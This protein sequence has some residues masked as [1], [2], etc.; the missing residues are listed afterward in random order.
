MMKKRLVL[1]LVVLLV[2]ISCKKKD[3][4]PIVNGTVL[5]SKV[6]DNDPN[7]ATYGSTLAQF[8]YN[9]KQLTSAAYLSGLWSGQCHCVINYLETTSFNYDSQGNL[10]GTTI[11]NTTPNYSGDIGSVITYNSNNI[12]GIRF[13][14][15]GNVADRDVTVTYQNGTVQTF[16][17]KFYN[18]QT[19]LNTYGTVTQN[20]NFSYNSGNNAIQELQTDSLDGRQSILT[21]NFDNKAGLSQAIPFWIYFN[22]DT[23]SF[24][25][26]G[27]ESPIGFPVTPGAGNPITISTAENDI[28]D[29]TYTLAYQYNTY[30]YPSQ[31]SF[32]PFMGIHKY[33]YIVVP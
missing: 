23:R 18:V 5:L 11:S 16:I 24:D 1:F 15:A 30:G 14:K 17:I 6:I 10:V 26:I 21:S 19:S 4:N 7:S 13:Y 3:S 22:I 25:I 9:G 29:F 12:S 28:I 8:S 31:I 27:G 20:I 32:G 33:E 2:V